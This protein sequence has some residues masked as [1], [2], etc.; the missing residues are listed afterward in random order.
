M[1][2][3]SE[4]MEL[5][6][7]LVNEYDLRDYYDKDELRELLYKTIEKKKTGYWGLFPDSISSYGPDRDGKFLYKMPELMKRVMGCVNDYA[8]QAGFKTQVPRN[9]WFN[10][11]TENAKVRPHP[12]EGCN[13]S[14]TFY[15][16]SALKFVID[17]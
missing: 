8:R 11:A 10:I 14:C 16:S 17:I 12:H 15:F 9:S 13:I 6:P 5:F 2:K 4:S 3:P 7:V 1:I